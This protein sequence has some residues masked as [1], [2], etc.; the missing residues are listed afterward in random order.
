MRIMFSDY[1]QNHPFNL[2]GLR[3]APAQ[4]VYIINVWDIIEAKI[5]SIDQGYKRDL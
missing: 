1:R 4:E 5:W 3:D 2:E